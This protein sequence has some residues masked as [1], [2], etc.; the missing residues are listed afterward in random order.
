MKEKKINKTN[1]I[2]LIILIIIIIL[3][4]VIAITQSAKRKQQQTTTRV[5]TTTETVEITDGYEPDVAG[6]VNLKEDGNSYI[7]CQGKERI[8]MT[9]LYY[10]KMPGTSKKDLYYFT[11]GKFDKSFSGVDII[12]GD[13]PDMGHKYAYIK[14]GK[15]DRNFTGAASYEHYMRIFK[16]GLYLDNYNGN[17]SMGGLEASCHNGAVRGVE[18]GRPDGFVPPYK[19]TI[20]D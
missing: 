14:N 5:S 17:V 7:L 8:Y 3:V 9:G 20:L 2:L 10:I 11:D 4:V 13:S 16:N 6:E 18:L 1:L 15:I 19:V 12:P